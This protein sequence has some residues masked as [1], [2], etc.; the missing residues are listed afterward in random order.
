LQATRNGV[1]DVFV[2]GL[3]PA[4]STLLFSSYL[5]GTDGDN[6]GNGI[7]LDRANNL[8]LTGLTSSTNFPNTGAATNFLR[9]A[10]VAKITAVSSPL[11]N[12]P[13][14]LHFTS[15]RFGAQ[16]QFELNMAGEPNHT[17]RLEFSPDLNQW[18][19]LTNLLSSPNGQFQYDD[20]RA[21]LFPR[22]FYRLR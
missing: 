7:A 13:P 18:L 22:G 15:F 6:L 3:N 17:Y 20:S 8:Y 12:M 11:T 21:S 5:G 9:T 2:A 10:F 16:K 19:P 1:L 14:A 4:G